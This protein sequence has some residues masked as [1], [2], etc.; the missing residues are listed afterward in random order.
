M[1][2]PFDFG[3]GMCCRDD[4][5][6]TTRRQFIAGYLGLLCSSTTALCE[7]MVGFHLWRLVSPFHLLFYTLAPPMAFLNLNFMHILILSPS[8][9]CYLRKG[10]LNS[11]YTTFLVV[12]AKMTYVITPQTH[13]QNILEAPFGIH[14]FV[15]PQLYCALDSHLV[16]APFFTRDVNCSVSL[17][18]IF[19]RCRG[20]S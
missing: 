14:A 6:S 16:L 12:A 17:S 4:S 2:N 10:S 18:S 9:F 13:T 5:T 11:A 20:K 1:K 8:C 15:V 19:I 7:I 3:S